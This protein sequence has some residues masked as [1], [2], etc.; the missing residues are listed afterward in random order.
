M[1]ELKW[2]E[3]EVMECLAVLPEIEDYEVSHT[4]RLNDGTLALLVTF[5][6][7]ESIAQFTLSRMETEEVVTSFALVIRDGVYYRNEKYGESLRFRDCVLIPTR[8]YIA[9]GFHNVFD[10]GLYP[11]GIDMELFARPTIRLLFKN[12]LP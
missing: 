6:Q 3:L 4:Y 1:P 7:Y 8:F 5:W 2:N 11:K 10:A 12:P 9:G